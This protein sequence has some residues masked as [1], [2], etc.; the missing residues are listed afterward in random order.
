MIIQSS[1]LQH[2]LWFNERCTVT[3]LDTEGENPTK[4]TSLEKSVH[5]HTQNRK[6]KT[7]THC[8]MTNSL[9][10]AVYFH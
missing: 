1:G 7:F 2:C 8:I 6:E 10:T 5:F 9:S 4:L 3:R